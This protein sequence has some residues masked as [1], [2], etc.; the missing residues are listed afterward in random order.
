MKIQSRT[1]IFSEM[2]Q[3]CLHKQSHYQLVLTERNMIKEGK[4]SKYINLTRFIWVSHEMH[5]IT[6]DPEPNKITA[7]HSSLA[8]Q[9]YPHYQTPL[10]SLLH[11][12]STK[13]W[14]KLEPNIYAFHCCGPVLITKDK[15]SSDLSY[16]EE[17]NA[18]LSSVTV[19]FAFMYHVLP[20]V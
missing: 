3:I 4:T 15:A 12:L 6:S 7:S 10:Q 19:H 17:N 14:G 18:G 2:G 13:F 5:N 1:R 16:L 11:K 8:A 20:L 9:H